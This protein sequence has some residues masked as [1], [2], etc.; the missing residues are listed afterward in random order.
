MLKLAC[1]L[2]DPP[3]KHR[4]LMHLAQAHAGIGDRR[5]A[6]ANLQEAEPLLPGDK[7]ALLERTKVRA[8]VDYFTRDFRSGAL[9]SERAI[10]M[11]RE[12]GV[13]SGTCRLV[14]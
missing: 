1:V 14:L 10:D 12:I 9:H 6:L 11:A 3:E 2:S 5:T 13:S 7:M 4:I 8:L